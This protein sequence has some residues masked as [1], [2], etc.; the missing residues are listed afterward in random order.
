MK[1]NKTLSRVFFDSSYFFRCLDCFSFD[2]AKRYFLPYAKLL[3]PASA[4]VMFYLCLAQAFLDLKSNLHWDGLESFKEGESWLA[5]SQKGNERVIEC[6]KLFFDE[7]KE[8]LNDFIVV[9]QEN[10]KLLVKEK[11]IPLVVTERP[12][13]NEEKKNELINKTSI[14]VDSSYIIDLIINRT[15]NKT[16]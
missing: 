9:L 16:A 12:V 4:L 14:T 13:W 8:D 10:I 1:Q 6:K 2:M 5:E 11:I 3:C 15:N 7:N